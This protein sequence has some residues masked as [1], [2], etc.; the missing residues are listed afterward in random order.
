MEQQTKSDQDQNHKYIKDLLDSDN[1]SKFL[2]IIDTHLNKRYN[3]DTKKGEHMYSYHLI[4]RIAHYVVIILIIAVLSY[5]LY[6][7]KI[8][9]TIY[10]T[11]IGSVIG[12]IV[13]NNSKTSQ[14]N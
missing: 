14:N 2:D 11:L 6:L 1:I 4:N 8:S 10:A 5:L 12:Y 9:D 3:F 7:N 13:G